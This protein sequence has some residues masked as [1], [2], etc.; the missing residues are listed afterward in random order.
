M[1]SDPMQEIQEEQAAAKRIEEEGL[2]AAL[3]NLRYKYGPM[4]E[5]KSTGLIFDEVLLS[6]N[7]DHP[8]ASPQRFIRMGAAD[9]IRDQAKEGA[10]DP[11]KDLMDRLHSSLFDCCAAVRMSV[12]TA[13][14]VLGQASSRPYLERLLEIETASPMVRGVVEIA[15]GSCSQDSGA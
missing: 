7:A 12:A 1:S 2:P 8:M 14:G 10:L 5:F 15:I 13:V 3:E 4:T 11:D 9:F 6:E